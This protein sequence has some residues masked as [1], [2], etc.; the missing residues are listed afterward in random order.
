MTWIVTVTF[1]PDGYVVRAPRRKPVVLKS[2]SEA[3]DYVIGRHR[4][5]PSVYIDGGRIREWRSDCGCWRDITRP[6]HLDQVNVMVRA[7]GISVYVGG[8]DIDIGKHSCDIA[9]VIRLVS[10]ICGTIGVDVRCVGE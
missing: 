8:R 10:A 1:C 7:S 2:L 3:K 5:L 9:E 6:G 4:D